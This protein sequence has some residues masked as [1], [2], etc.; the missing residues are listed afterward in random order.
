MQ[1]IFSDMFVIHLAT[2]LNVSQCEVNNAINSFL[3]P[4]VQNLNEP[5]SISKK[6]I[7]PRKCSEKKESV[8]T[9]VLTINTCER[10]P[11]GKSENC[12]KTAKMSIKS[13]DGVERWYCGTE[14][15]G[16]FKSIKSS[17]K[18]QAKVVPLKTP[19]VTNVNKPPTLKDKKDFTDVKSR[20]LLNSVLQKKDLILRSIMV[21]NEKLWVD[22]STRI[23]FDKKTQ[24]AYGILDKDN[25][26]ILNLTDKEIRLLEASNTLIKKQIVKNEEIVVEN[27]EE[28]DDDEELDDGEGL[29]DDDEELDD[30]ELDDDE[31]DKE[32]LDD[33]ENDSEELDE[34]D[35]EELDEDDS[36]ELDEE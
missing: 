30:E 35:S 25:E 22:H 9:P 28:L 34:D 4:I 6:V 3:I 2:E 36:E 21:K 23:L 10:K 26:T 19:L 33:G 18:R 15:S 13:E 24:E 8:K 27:K 5:V 20:S 31:N 17:V 14:K 12:G 11:R 29:D 32:E 7:P 16:C 1:K